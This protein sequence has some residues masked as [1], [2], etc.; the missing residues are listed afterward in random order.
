MPLNRVPVVNWDQPIVDKNGC[1][2]PYF[3]T[4]LLQTLKFAGDGAAAI[5]DLTGKQDQNDFLDALSAFGGSGHLVRTGA[6]GVVARTVT[7]G[8]GIS[9]ANGSGVSGNPTVTLALT[10]AIV[11]TALG[12]TAANAAL[13]LLIANN[14]S[15]VANPAT[16]RNNL[17]L[18]SMATQAAS[19]VAITGGSVT[20]ITDLA[21]ADGGTG[22]STAPAARTNLGLGT[23]ATQDA[24]NVAITGGSITGLTTFNVPTSTSIGWASEASFNREA[25]N[26]TGLRNGANVQFLRI[27]G[28]F[29]DLSNNEY[30]RFGYASGRFE[31]AALA[32]GTGTAR[33]IGILTGAGGGTL[34]W[35]F[36]TSGNVIAGTTNAYDVGAPSNAPRSVYAGT[37]F[38]QTA[39][40]T[41]RAGSG[42]PEG[43]VTAPIGSLFSRTDGGAATSL[44]VKE[45]G[46]GNTGWIA[47]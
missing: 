44:Y 7:A 8:A 5:D 32:T 14:L 34:R 47:K 31:I 36:D 45:S 28:T 27:Y 39:G 41:W 13:T 33:S 24:N 17:G 10:G 20:G 26:V 4:V 23:I 43:V 25:A 38:A 2:T 18:G 15:D 11:N 6:G 40:P 9:V 46:A 37:S 21:V 12:Y 30:L 19:A 29:T 42:S 35:L 16:A 1:V 3:Q 22:A